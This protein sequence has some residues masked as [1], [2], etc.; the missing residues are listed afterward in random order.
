M[1]ATAAYPIFDKLT[2]ID[3]YDLYSLQYYNKETKTKDNKIKY[4]KLDVDRNGII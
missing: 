4:C 2:I 3:C 1:T